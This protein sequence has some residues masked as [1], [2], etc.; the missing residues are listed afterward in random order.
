MEEY[1]EYVKKNINDILKYVIDNDNIEII[2]EQVA[3]YDWI[4]IQI[5]NIEQLSSLLINNV[6]ELVTNDVLIKNWQFGY[7]NSDISNRKI[8]YYLYNEF[9]KRDSIDY[10]MKIRTDNLKDLLTDM[11]K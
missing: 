11:S 10:I 8:D 4:G 7:L 2:I 1:L 3:N 6:N 9:V 5:N